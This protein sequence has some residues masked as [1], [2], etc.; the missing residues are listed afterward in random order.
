MGK[1]IEE[2][3]SASGN[4]EEEMQAKIQSQEEAINQSI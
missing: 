1:Q 2:K 4:I 3:E